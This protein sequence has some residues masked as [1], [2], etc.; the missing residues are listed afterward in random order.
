MVKDLK[1]K[2]IVEVLNVSIERNKTRQNNEKNQNQGVVTCW[3]VSIVIRSFT[4]RRI[5]PSWGSNDDFV[6]VYVAFA[7]YDDNYATVKVLVVRS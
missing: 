5:V 3:S 6:Q 7:L 4:S 2:N 1:V